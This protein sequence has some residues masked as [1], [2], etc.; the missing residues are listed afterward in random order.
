M[1]LQ[2]PFHLWRFDQSGQCQH[3]PY[4]PKNKK[5]PKNANATSYPCLE[6]HDM[7]C[8]YYDN[9]DSATSS[10]IPLYNLPIQHDILD[11]S[12]YGYVGS[13]DYGI[14]KMHIQEFAENAADWMH[15]GSIHGKMMFPFTQIEIP[16]I[17][18]WLK[19]HHEPAT[20]IG[21]GTNKD[22]VAIEQNNYGPNNKYFL[23]FINSSRCIYCLIPYTFA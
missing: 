10:S 20:Y 9:R 13:F 3:I 22:S 18:K 16:I 12:Q 4:L 11:R 17:H 8:V 21:G 6:Y 15:F 19:I 14:V 5:I 7:V 2:C 23:Y 1:K